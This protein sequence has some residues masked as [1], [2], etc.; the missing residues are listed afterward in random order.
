LQGD[1]DVKSGSYSKSAFDGDL[2]S[3]SLYHL[4]DDLESESRPTNLSTDGPIREQP[5]LNVGRHSL[6]CIF[7]GKANRVKH[8]VDLTSDGDPS[9][10]GY[11]GNGII[12]KVVQ[13]REKTTFIGYY[14][15][16][17]IQAFTPHD[18]A[19]DLRNP[20]ERQ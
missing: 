1:Y 12:H 19:L 3:V 18:D 9:S 11:R 20:S 10:V 2:S 4:L 5:I 14:G 17:I 13:H 8:G 6:P 16:K 7:H 15:W